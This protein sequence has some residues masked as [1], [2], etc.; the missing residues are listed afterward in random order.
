[1]VIDAGMSLTLKAGGHHIVINPE[2]IFSSV[3][4][5]EGGVPLAGVPPVLAMSAEG[6]ASVA[7]QAPLLAP[8]QRSALMAKKPVCAICE[9][10]K[11]Q[12]GAA[13]A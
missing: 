8:T 7:L 11:Q 1:M 4:I 3:P 2:G 6:S 5:D 10:A 9:V 12:K 13:H